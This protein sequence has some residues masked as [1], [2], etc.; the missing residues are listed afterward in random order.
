MNARLRDW[1]TSPAFANDELK[2]R[3]VALLDFN[4]LLL[5]GLDALVIL[6][7]V[8]G[9]RD[10]LLMVIDA[11]VLA[12]FWLVRRRLRS[13][14]V[15]WISEG[16]IALSLVAVTLVIISRGTV[17][18]PATTGYILIIVMA[19]L[20]LNG[21]GV[22]VTTLV[23]ALAVAGLIGAEQAGLIKPVEELV[24]GADWVIYAAAFVGAGGLGYWGLQSIRTALARA[25]REVV[26]HQ[27][28]EAA[29]RHS[30]AQLREAQHLA[31][32]GSWDWD[33]STQTLSWSDEV[34]QIFDLSPAETTATVDLLES[35][36]HPD[37]RADFLQQRNQML[38]EART[39]VIDHRIARRDGRVRYLQERAEV[40][41]DD[42]GQP[43]RVIGTVQDITDRKQAEY[44][45]RTF[46][47]TIDHLLFVLDE[48][49]RIL[50]TNAAVSNRLGYAPDELLGQPVL[51]VHPPAQQ[52][53]AAQIV[54]DMLAG[55]ADYCPVPLQAKDGRQFPV[56]TRIVHGEWNGQPALFGVTKDLSALRASEEKFA[57]AF[58]ANPTLMALNE[59]DTGRYLD[60]NAAFLD[61]LGY[62][63]EEVIGQT[64]LSLG[65]FS[66][67]AR[68]GEGLQ[69]L[70][71]Q[72]S[73]RNFEVQIRTKAG[74]VRHGLFSAEFIQLQ[75]RRLLLTMM[76]DLTEQQQAEAA[77]RESEEKYRSVVAAMSEG[78]LMQNVAGEV[79][80]CN[81]AVERIL[82]LTPDQLMGRVPIDQ[83]WRAIRADGSP[84]PVE[85]QPSFVTLRTG[86]AFRNVEIGIN[87]PTGELVWVNVN[88]EPLQRPGEA[89]PYAVVASFVD[90]TDRKLMEAALR[91]S[92]ERWSFALEGS[93]DGVWDWDTTTDRVFYSRQ[94][95]ALLGYAEAEIGSDLTEWFDR[96][97]PA[98]I[99]AVRDELQRHFNGESPYYQSEQRL[100]AK[101]GTYRWILDRGRVISRQPNGQPARVIGTHT[102]ITIR[103][104]A[105]RL[106]ERRAL[107]AAL[108]NEIGRQITAALAVDDVLAR[109]AHLMHERLGLHHVGIFVFNQDRT[110]LVLRGRAGNYA[111]LFAADHH[112]KID[113]GIVG[114]VAQHGQ[115]RLA[116]DVQIDPYY[117]NV[118]GEALPTRAE[119]AV[120]IL[121]AGEVRGVLDVQ[122]P[123]VNAFDE[124]D[125]L[126]KETL[127]DQIA[128]ALE[129]ARLYGAAQREI[130][131]RVQ[132][133]EA[134][135]E[136][137]AMLNATGQMARV[138][139]W[140]LDAATLS[141]KWTAET[142]R[143][144]DLP[145]DQLPTLTEASQFYHPDDRPLVEQAFQRALA[146]GDA[147]DLEL[148]FRTATGRARW[149]Q[150]TGHAHWQ[151]GRIIKLS[152]TFQDITERKGFE[153]A[154]LLLNSQLE[155][156]VAARTAELQAA[157]VRLT[158]LDHLKDDFLSRISHE[159]R[160]PLSGI[161]IALE[162]L[163][164]SKPE[165]R[166]RYQ[167]RLKQG[168]ERLREM[169][170][171]VLLFA[172]LNRYTRPATLVPIDLNELI[173]GH[174]TTW[175]AL[176]AAH[177]LTLQVDLAA[178][179]VCT[180]VDDELLTQ[181]LTR[182]VINAVNYTPA[183]T[184]TVMTALREEDDQRWAIVSV[185]DTGPGITPDDL[186]HIFE[187][188]YRGRAASDYKTPG[189]GIGLAIS[190]EIV[191]RLG[192]R[193]TVETQ[194]GFGSTFTVW[195]PVL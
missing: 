126:T 6:A 22:V 124:N 109:A 168:A 191:E 31:Q 60:V 74:D 69:R 97:H 32:L 40:L 116:N 135:R 102:D 42:R 34:Y 20:L 53:E 27:A 115:R 68:R 141:L 183:G 23:S 45:F 128:V 47:N 35:F 111:H 75:D 104:E 84:L 149:V 70:Q 38:A 105:E 194:V 114:W 157:N 16:L 143:I 95:K 189:T 4:L 144:H 176:S 136:S 82:G 44:N 11:S 148:R 15:K 10:P 130:A 112:L 80:A 55:H 89:A 58:A 137:E 185:S 94:W 72:N 119:L 5:M 120:P 164:T 106:L 173:E 64:V 131:E 62:R 33:L 7:T 142:Y 121:V 181:A 96:V 151:A 61:T 163:E 156:R 98:D 184:V 18:A 122:S 66:D 110:Q 76:N 90:V 99:S 167:Q 57:K 117:V 140:E 170:E 153:E 171:D 169:I 30:E 13:G 25:E 39:A 24:R 14:Q 79:I 93:G 166:E 127:A 91:E 87:K 159:L 160:T 19:G 179:L 123:Q 188:F 92:E 125:V 73:L 172:Q 177:D 54:A 187:R 71:Q 86:Q 3:Q 147:F 83:N 134:L 48:Q 132:A 43:V 152:G 154:L 158:E 1:L 186:P 50:F 46:F 52:A 88:S 78:I 85:D 2:T 113:Q 108:I 107:Q 81:L 28:T 162:L 145:P 41:Q 100:R 146:R 165:K 36:I 182:L 103:K 26:A 12:I 180:Y 138:G 51:M 133:E 67:L 129:N 21:R 59:A 49:G 175:R 17:R 63:R 155:Q 174:V 190:R 139:G 193:L 9:D 150:S 37:D 195:L 8:F 29:L 118:Y 77:L 65:L 178:N 56:E 192:G 101:D 161:L